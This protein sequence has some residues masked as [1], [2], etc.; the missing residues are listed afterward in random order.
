MIR[1]PLKVAG[2]GRCP[3]PRRYTVRVPCFCTFSRRPPNPPKVALRHFGQG[4]PEQNEDRCQG[5]T[6]LTGKGI[7]KFLK[8]HVSLPDSLLV[9]D[10]YKGYNAV[11]SLMAHEVINHSA[12]Y[13]VGDVHTNTIEGFWA[14]IKRAWYG[15]HHHYSKKYMPLFIA[16]TSWNTTSAR[17]PTCLRRSCA[18]CL[19]KKA[20]HEGRAFTQVSLGEEFG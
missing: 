1:V 10:E 16:E 6:D 17:T 9:T 15:S 19:R 3:G 13:A 12:E 8:K 2:H 5:R 11:D 4:Q 20:Q 7:V 18:G 14:L